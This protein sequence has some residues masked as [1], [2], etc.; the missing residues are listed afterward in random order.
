[1]LDYDG[2]I[3]HTIIAATTITILPHVTAFLGFQLHLTNKPNPESIL[4]FRL[5]SNGEY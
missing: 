2:E 4:N 3:L 5:P 1:L